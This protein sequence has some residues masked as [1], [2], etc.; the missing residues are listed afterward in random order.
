MRSFAGRWAA[1]LLALIRA[2]SFL[3]A[4]R[5]VIMTGAVIGVLFRK[6]AAGL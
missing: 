6:P 3:A 1:A 4:S 5:F 2:E